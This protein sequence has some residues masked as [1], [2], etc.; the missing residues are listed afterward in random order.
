MRASG[1]QSPR[2]KPIYANERNTRA[3]RTKHELGG[4]LLNRREI[5]EWEREN[6][7]PPTDSGESGVLDTLKTLMAGHGRTVTS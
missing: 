7:A 3:V 1:P 4:Y 5:D 6:A 2:P